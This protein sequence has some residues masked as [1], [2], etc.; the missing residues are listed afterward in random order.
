M[1]HMKE[2]LNISG[3]SLSKK[4]I[5]EIIKEGAQKIL[6]QALE[7]EIEEFIEKYSSLKTETGKKRIVRNGYQNERAFQTKAGNIKIR[8]PRARDKSGEKDKIQFNSRLIPPYLRRAKDINEFIPFLYLK[9][10][11]TGDFSEVLT[12]L[13][14]DEVTIS[15]ATVV[16]LKEKWR[17]EYK[18]W[19]DRNLSGKKYIYWWADGIYFN[20]RLDDDRTCIL[21][22]IGATADGRKELL[23]IEEGYRESEISWKNII[24]DL[25]K[26]GLSTGP[27]LAIGDGSLGFWNALAKEFPATRH[28]R[29]WVHR[30]ANVLDKMP[31]S[32]QTQAKRN[33]QEIYMSPTK[34]DAL[35]AFENFISLYEHKYPKAVECLF[36]TKDETM[37]FYDFPEEHWKHIRTTNP[38]EST[39]ATV[40]LRTYKTKGSGSRMETLTM[41]FKLVQSAEK[42]WQKINCR[43]KI[44]LVL[45]GRKFENGV[46][47]DA[48]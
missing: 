32:V 7:I 39:F 20:V 31:K 46:L 47:Q 26:R 19:N 34:A 28:Q 45:E 22:I 5:D 42:K 10:I 33:I 38:I 18:L 48:A 23:A 8:V 35:K 30:M 3:K 37:A 24:L 40:R 43:E 17:E 11:S 6:Q 25:K 14:G 27:S 1:P 2:I 13:L 21:V 4:S 44:L 16:K 36:K 29:C 15:P 41:V 9:G 12:E